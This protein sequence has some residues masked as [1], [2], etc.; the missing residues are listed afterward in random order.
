MEE[1][2]RND[3]GLLISNETKKEIK[4]DNRTVTT[5]E[6]INNI[7]DRLEVA[8]KKIKNL[9]DMQDNV[10][11]IA[12][13]M[14]RCIDLLSK[15]IKGPKVNGKISEMRTSN[16]LF[17]IKT[18]ASIEEEAMKTRKDINELYKEKDAILRE[19]RDNYNKE[20]EEKEK[21]K[22][23]MLRETDKTKEEPKK[24]TEEEKKENI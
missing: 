12:K 19:N 9:N 11:S 24:E 2:K 16:K 5:K 23:E 15:S 10:N 18:T 20:K 1:N 6:K 4:L 8:K 7:D 21:L 3:N 17:L 13:N 14:N 22:F